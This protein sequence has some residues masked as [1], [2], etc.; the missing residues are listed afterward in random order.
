M[1]LHQEHHFERE[2]C[3]HLA[4]SG[5]LHEEGDA[6]LFD[7]ASGLFLPDLLA[8]I[9]ATQPDSLQRLV[10]THGPA[11]P[12]VLAERL[13]KNLNERGTL[14]VVRRGVEMLGLREPLELAQF[15]P[16]LAINPDIQARY[17]A[18]RLRVVRQVRHSPNNPGDELDLVLFLNGIPVATAELK[19]DFTQGVD[20]AVDQYRFDR[21]PHPKGGVLEP[22]LGFPGGALVHFAVSQ[23]EVMMTTRLAGTDTVF[24]PFNR[25]NDGGAGNAPNPDGYATA[26]LWEGV[27]TRE[28]WLD[29]L[30]RYLIG[31]RDDKKQLA[32]V[33]FPRYHQ[34]DATR[35]LVADVLANGA[36]GRYLIQ[37]SAGSGKTNSIAWTAHFLADLHDEH[38][39]KLFD[40]VLV[41]SDRTVLDAQ[42]KEALFD[43]QRT[44]GVVASI[45]NESGSKSAQ[46]SQALK[47]G[48]KIIV[49]TI[50]TFPFALQ[51][52]QEL[53]ATEG[54]RFAVIADEAHSSQTGEAAVKLK[55]VLSAEEW[56]Q[57]Q[58]GG[59]VD[60]EALIA[61]QM[62]ARVGVKGL[63]YVAFTATPKAKTLELFGGKGEDGLPKPFHVYS[64]RQAIE[65]KFIL[66]VL[67]NY[68]TY[69][70]A[71]KLAH[72]GQEYDQLQVERSSALKGIM[73]W[74][75]LHPYNIASK[76]QVVVEHFRENVQPLLGGKAK[77]M[78]VVGSRKEA[79]R[80][81]K[82]IRGYI[83]RQHYALG[84]LVA[85]SGEVND[86]D[87][88]PDAVTESNQLLNPG[89]RGR[90]IREV[91]KEPDYHLLL[92]ANKFQTGFDQ[93]LLCGMYVDKMLGGIQAVQT[94]SRLNRSY[95]GKDTTYVLD[96]VN[97]PAEILKAFRTYYK[98]VELASVTDPNQVYDLRAKLDAAG[99]YDS[100]EVERV[101]RVEMDYAGT[102]KQLDAAIAPVADRLLK[103]YKALQQEKIESEAQDDQKKAKAAKDQLDA[104]I[105][106]KNDMGAYTRL[107]AFL[108]QI[109]DY[110]NTDIE[111]RFLFFRR[112]IPL[113]EF[114]RE[115]DTVDLSKVVL[116]HH[117][118]KGRGKQ[119]MGLNQDGSY[120]LAPMDAVGSGSVQ[121]KQQ[122]YLVEIIEKVNGL[123]QGELTDDDQLVY[124]NGVI[125]GKLLEND[126]LV[127]QASSNSKEQFANSPDLKDALM[128]AIMDAFEAHQ[129]MSTQALDSERVRDGLKDILLG[130][131]Q[132]YEA[133]RARSLSGEPPRLP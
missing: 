65:E 77:A 66:D 115:R 6:D 101:A 8:W 45:T 30:H 86:P 76:V 95:P 1:N 2:I 39:T 99:Y 98:T 42:L 7:R 12:Q 28:S 84:V 129:T 75:R 70:L 51:A 133:L 21:H 68:T 19:S 80:W 127:Q 10:K 54:K 118:L 123:F 31:K 130:P 104:L 85:F 103:R 91:F 88:F 46:L 72:N 126:T 29:I 52:V 13:R 110:G 73:Q 26:Y 120:K 94:L 5:W 25:G 24:L 83:E 87:S 71:F 47:D 17:A 124:V 90:D 105:L 60:T 43:F 79:V 11:T 107:Y 67:K 40:S 59:E 64:M 121:E 63:T 97:D 34:L 27:W 106:F 16:A 36:G 14:D 108:G 44:T 9:E 55:Q 58:D 116:T 109:F 53:A 33:I 117:T 122:A 69:N 102:Q 56:A 4:A 38:H 48:K 119:P 32:N 89:L 96:F 112:L 100:F 62:E 114:G 15:K 132:L 82:A 37:H 3:A 113:L 50:Q 49:C 131:A 81:Q 57:L 22:L 35:Q 93:P 111:K 23:S 74:V 125:K 18:N 41:V 20:D 128:H 92:V 78:V 61:A